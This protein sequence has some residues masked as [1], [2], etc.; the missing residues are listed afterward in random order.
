MKKFYLVIIGS[1]ILNGR[2]EDLHFNFLKDELT[3]RNYEL[4]ATFVLKDDIK[5]MQDVF[6]LVKNDNDSV[7]FSFGGIG[8]TLDDCTRAVSAKVFANNVL[9]IHEEG[10]KILEKKFKENLPICL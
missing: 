2:R 4:F 5:L 6:S 3:K 1:E 7:M 8:A 9:E 10:K